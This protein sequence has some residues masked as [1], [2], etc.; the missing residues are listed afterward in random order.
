MGAQA[1]MKELIVQ[2]AILFARLAGRFSAW[3]LSRP[4]RLLQQPAR[5]G[6]RPSSPQAQTQRSAYN[7]HE[8]AGTGN[9][10]PRARART[11][12]FSISLCKART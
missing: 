11:A 8:R 10:P 9:A 1:G 2:Q 7:A 4:A 12:P 6:V 5:R 3:G